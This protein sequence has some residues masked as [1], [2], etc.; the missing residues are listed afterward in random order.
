MKIQPKSRPENAKRCF[1]LMSL[2][3]LGLIATWL[4]APTRASWE[5]ADLLVFRTLN[6]TLELGSAWQTLWA[7]LNSRIADLITGAVLLAL[8]ITSFLERKIGSRAIYSLAIT[9]LAI[10]I[11]REIGSEL[12]VEKLCDYQRPSPTLALS[13]THR[14]TELVPTI[15]SKDSS[16]WSFPGD[17]GHV[18]ICLAVYLGFWA[19]RHAA[20]AA[21]ILTALVV[22][23][24]LVGGG[25]WTTDIVVGSGS[26]ALLTMAIL[27]P[28]GLHDFLV[29]RLDRAVR[30]VFSTDYD[31][32]SVDTPRRRDAA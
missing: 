5:Q 27:I 32:E 6:N 4:W 22:L 19:R 25:H 23:P 31:A 17:H 9:M 28:T 3:A 18:A 7:F 10:F 15:A 24:R 30:R 20:T 8:L 26:M 14:L 12:I 29:E 11:G 13:N 21:W 16:P 2:T 1:R